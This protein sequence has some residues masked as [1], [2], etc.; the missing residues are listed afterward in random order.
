MFPNKDPSLYINYAPLYDESFKFDDPDV[1]L[2]TIKSI[3]V[4]LQY[5]GFVVSCDGNIIYDARTQVTSR[6]MLKK[7]EIKLWKF[8]SIDGK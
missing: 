1:I 4:F 6:D 3:V 5:M 7:L 8:R 2:N